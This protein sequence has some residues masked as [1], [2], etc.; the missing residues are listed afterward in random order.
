MNE[1]LSHDEFMAMI[2]HLESVIA[3]LKGLTFRE[4]AVIAGY[5]AG[6]TVSKI[7]RLLGCSRSTVT[8]T[9]TRL[10]ARGIDL[11]RAR[12]AGHYTLPNPHPRY[13]ATG[14]APGGGRISV[15]SDTQEESDADLAAMMA[16]YG[17]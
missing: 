5:R 17:P 4:R 11:P 14:I 13:T 12:H 6:T 3:D 15:T 7:A 16:P 8:Q 1:A 10:R 2:E 9:A